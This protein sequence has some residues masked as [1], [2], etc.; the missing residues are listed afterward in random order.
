M[1]NFMSEFSGNFKFHLVPFLAKLC[2]VVAKAGHEPFALN[3]L[4]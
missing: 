2:N 4:I 3:V 1:T